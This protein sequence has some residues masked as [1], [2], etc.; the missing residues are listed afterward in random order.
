MF[1]FATFYLLIL[2][3][4]ALYSSATAQDSGVIRGT[5]TDQQE[6]PLPGANILLVG[7]NKGTSSDV[8]GNFRLD[9]LQPGRYEIRI[10]YL[11]YETVFKDVNIPSEEAESLNIQMTGTS[12][13]D[14]EVVVRGKLSKGQA[15]A[16]NQQKNASNITYV[17]ASEVF[18]QYPDVSAAETVQRFPGVSI[19]RDQGEGE[20]VQIRGLSEDFNSLTID[21]LRIPSMEGDDTRGVGLDLIQSKLIETIKVTKTL[22]PDMDADALGGAVDFQMKKAGN[23]PEF[24]LQATG[25]LNEQESV[26][27]DKGRDIFG[28]SAIGGF[29]FADNKIGLMA[30]GSYLNTDRGSLFS[31]WR[32]ASETGDELRRHRATDYDINR[33]RYGVIAN[34]DFQASDVSSFELL[35]NHNTYIDDEIRRQ[36]RFLLEDDREERRTRNRDERQFLN[37]VKLT[38]NHILGSVAEV[39]YSGSWSEGREKLPDRTESRFRRDVDFS[40]LSDEEIFGLEPD[41]VFPGNNTPLE[42]TRMEFDPRRTEERNL[43][44]STDITFNTGIAERTVFKAGGKFIDKNRDFFQSE[45]RFQPLQEILLDPDGNFGL[46]DVRFGDGTFNELFADPTSV[47]DSREDPGSYFA[48]EQ[49]VAGYIMG[50]TFLSEKWSALTGVRIENTDNNYLQFATGN[51][52][53]G[54]FTTILPSFHLNYEPTEGFKIRAAVTKG[55]ARP[56]YTNLVPIDVVDN[57]DF[58]ISRGNTD[59]DP[60]TTW[61]Y[62][63]TAEKFTR[64]LGHFSAGVFY[65]DFRDPVVT[66]S[67]TDVIDGQEFVVFQP[68]N[69]GSADLLGFELASRQNLSVLNIEALKWFGITANYTYIYTNTEFGSIEGQDLPLPNSPSHIASGSLTY[70]NGINGFSSVIAGVYRSSVF[71][72]F[73]GGDD[74][75]LDETFHLDFSARYRI[76]NSFN[77]FLNVN[78][79]TNES[80]TEINR[81]PGT[82]NARIH[83]NERYGR[84]TTAGVQYNF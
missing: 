84:W 56:N 57:S 80:N 61:N 40:G 53:D 74:I 6:F 3:N 54:G 24:E 20:F 35:F 9:R 67:F 75:W 51:T 30:G 21:G 41:F 50:E 4:F 64:F 31:S 52:G 59:L 42:F 77:M 29:R 10:S 83:E 11:G 19:V 13:G 82:S 69:S 18:E 66:Q 44:F 65:K 78:N 39:T 34:F 43:T 12:V 45:T 47:S 36:A 55:L 17:V 32:Y 37:L 70:D 25:G 2:F 76:N 28:V 63:L 14:M 79:I 15:K 60:T 81:E 7:T 33:E 16:L 23:R 8:N 58:E 27:R 71:S 1:R 46:V 72:K 48:E 22:T 5:V 62:D 73:E 49:I 38:G 68:Q 26:L